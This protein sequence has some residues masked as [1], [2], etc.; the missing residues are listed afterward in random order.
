M[1]QALVRFPSVTGSESEAQHFL[2]HR[3][4]DWGLEVDLWAP[5]RKEVERHPAFCDDGLPVERPNVVA[6]WGEG[7]EPAALILNGHIDVVPP[8]DPS[9]WNDDPFSGRID[10]GVLFGRGACDMKGGLAAA[11]MAVRAAQK[12]GVIPRRP[13]LLQSVVGE[14]TGGLGTLAAIERGYRA[15]AAVIA[16]PTRLAVCPVQSGAL[17]FR[18]HVTGKSAHGALR[19][20]GIN[21]IEK[22]W[23]LWK[24][25][26]DLEAKRHRDFDHPLYDRGKLAAP[27]SIGKLAAGDWPST[28]PETA[29]AEGRFG[30]FPGEE[31]ATARRDFEAAV[32]Q[33]SKEDAWLR[34]HP[35]RVEWFEGQFEPGETDPEAPILQQLSESHE[36]MTGRE[37]ASH[38]VPYGSDLRLF[39]RYAGM[40]AVL[41]GPGDV[42]L[43][44]ADNESVSLE[45]LVAAAEVMTMLICRTLAS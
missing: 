45:E 40:P 14:E 31:C 5:E 3:W 41:Y 39:T 25:L 36:A 42:T 27:V 32:W 44:H 30:V 16:E 29:V 22:L 18:L 1:A 43:A 19:Q 17:S 38:G 21:A 10:D 37:P 7:R 6:R 23:P 15:D 9:R 34:K 24:A 33:A 35:P 4:K 2:A 12:L 13:I 8:G 20:S 11:T 26:T 28:V